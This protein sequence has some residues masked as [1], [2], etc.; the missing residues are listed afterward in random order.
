MQREVA[1]VLLCCRVF[2]KTADVAE[3]IAFVQE[4]E[5]DWDMVYRV[6]ERHRIRPLVYRVLSEARVWTRE[7]A[8]QGEQRFSTFCRVF[9]V[10]AFERQM[11][12]TRIAGLLRKQGIAVKV[13]K[14]LDFSRVVYGDIGLR[15]FTDTDIMVDIAD[16]TQVIQIMISEGYSCSGMDFFRRFPERY[17]TMYK[18]IC[19]EREAPRGAV[20]SF[21]FHYRPVKYF[22]QEQYS[23]EELLGR[24]YLENEVSLRGYYNLMLLNHGSSDYFPNL[25]ALVDMMVLKQR[26]TGELPEALRRFEQLWQALAVQLLHY[27]VVPE[28]LGTDKALMR[29]ID[30]VMKRLL[31]VRIRRMSYVKRVGIQVGFEKEWI[32]KARTIWKGIFFLLVPNGEDIRGQGSS[33]FSIYYFTKAFR[34]I[35]KNLKLL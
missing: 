8:K 11:E 4:K 13:Y 17:V 12:L 2:V 14:G 25:R 3:L 15:E 29:T 23:F 30:A 28:N 21:E 31:R 22:M 5:L 35:K 20:Y 24:G 18:D 6:S 7:D 26:V 32:E 27:Q 9:S 19:F 16:I 34:L 1:F 33:L 10:F